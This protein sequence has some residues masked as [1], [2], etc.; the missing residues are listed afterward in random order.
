MAQRFLQ[1]PLRTRL[2]R[3]IGLP[4]SLFF[5]T[6]L[7]L[8][9]NRTFHDAVTSTGVAA[10]DLARLH[11]AKLDGTLAEAARVP[12]LHARV[13]ESGLLRDEPSLRRY[14]T[15]VLVH[16]PGIYGSCLAFEPDSFIPGQ[17]NFCPYVYRK[18]GAPI[19]SLLA[20]PEY[21]H[22]E[23][24]WYRKPKE[25]GRALWTEPFFDEG[26]GNVLMTTRAVPFK[27]PDT[28]AF[29]GVATIDI[30][31]DALLEGLSRLKVADTGYTLLL[32]PEG[33]ILS[34]PDREKI[35]KTGLADLNPDLA[36]QLSPGSE[37]FIKS[38]DPLRPRDAWI[39]YAPVPGAG[40]TLALVYPADEIFR[41]AQRLLLK[42]VIIGAAGVILLFVV[43][44][45]VARSVSSPVADLAAAARE[46][47]AGNLDQRISGK[48][49]IDEVRD[50]GAAFEKMTRDLRLHLDELRSTTALT[51]RLAGELSA[52]RRIQMSMLPGEWPTGAPAGI[53]LRAV[54]QPAREVGGDFYD[55][56][57][58]DHERISFLVGDVSGKG[59]PAALFMAMTQTLFKGLANPARGAAEVMAGVNRALCD[60]AHTGMFVTLVYGVLHLPTGKLE[61]CNAGHLDPF[62]IR[63][64]QGLRPVEGNGNNP[65]LGLLRDLDFVC[66]EIQLHPGDRLVLFT[67]G[68]TEALDRDE[69]LYSVERLQRLLETGPADIGAA[70]LHDVRTHTGDQDPTDDLTVLVVEIPAA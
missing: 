50:L 32:S 19:Y 53:S 57:Q 49:N 56:R 30:S 64:G 70:L 60:Q 44:A 33:R 55:Y 67:D 36:Q 9:I 16:T 18:D 8:V 34:C 15:D 3:F 39:A 46:V 45:F 26:G 13:L 12:H 20:P 22:F 66:A 21:D 59:V 37:G 38:T 58:I 35:M 42:L 31:L 11:A 65:A 1:G 17:K 27:H 43:L 14:L 25:A 52:A 28:G 63:P 4:A 61:L 47:A 68:V 51:S 23:W 2:T 69:Q 41:D 48:V 29:R 24:D 10:Q 40:F 5:L 54:I 7:G 6:T 62:L